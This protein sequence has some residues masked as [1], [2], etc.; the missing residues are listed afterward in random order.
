MEFKPSEKLIQNFWKSVRKTESCWTWTGMKNNKGYGF[1]S[2]QHG[3]LI[4]A[5]RLSWIIHFGQIPDGL[6]VCHKCDTPSCTNPSHLFTGTASDNML[7]KIMKGRD[8][9]DG[10]Y[11]NSKLSYKDVNEI[12]N[13]YIGG[14]ITQKQLAEK[15]GTTRENIHYV[16]K[17]K[18]WKHLDSKNTT[19]KDMRVKLSEKQIEEIKLL[20]GRE[21]HRSIAKKFNIS[22]THVTRLLLN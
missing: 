3:E 16:I 10:A 11:K 9:L 18:S 6:F 22:K 2:V 7:D 13:I 5:H 20:K 8:Y 21:S 14:N 4:G 12:R 15:Y 19:P 1:L 17:G